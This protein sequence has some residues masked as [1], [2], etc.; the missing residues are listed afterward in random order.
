[1]NAD[2]WDEEA[3]EARL[4]DMERECASNSEASPDYYKILNVSR[5]ASTEQV[6]D[7]YKRLSLLFHPDRHHDAESREWAHRQFNIIN[8]AYEMLTDPR[9]RA[10]YDQL[11]EE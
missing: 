3:E 8:H 1:M 5:H 10:A 2:A 11:G 6:R 4:R 9:S 7:S